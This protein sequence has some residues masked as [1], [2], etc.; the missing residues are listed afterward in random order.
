MSFMGDVL[1]EEMSLAQLA[2][3]TGGSRRGR[4]RAARR[5]GDRAGRRAASVR[6]L[7]ADPGRDRLREGDGATSREDRRGRARRVREGAVGA[8]RAAGRDAARLALDDRQA[9]ARRRRSRAEATDAAHAGGYLGYE[10]VALA[11]LATALVGEGRLDGASSAVARAEALAAERFAT[12]STWS[13]ARAQVLAATPGGAVERHRAAE[14]ACA[15]V[16][17]GAGG[18]TARMELAA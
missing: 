5:G 11:T 3:E 9:R 7:L 15:I 8:R 2:L 4:A 1:E 12:G 14:R 13:F 18:A 10:E 17:R 16:P 6:W